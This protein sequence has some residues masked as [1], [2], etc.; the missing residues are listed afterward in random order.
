MR[1]DF[2]ISNELAT[3][4]IDFLYDMKC[5]ARGWYSAEATRLIQELEKAAVT[6]VN[7]V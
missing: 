1:K 3:K 6:E 2:T 5:E 4:I 7:L